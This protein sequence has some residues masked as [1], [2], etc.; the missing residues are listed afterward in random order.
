MKSIGEL[1]RSARIK[2]SLTLDQIE[3][4][5]KIHKRFIKAIEEEDWK[6]LPEFPVVV[7]FVKSIVSYLDI[8]QARALAFLRRDYPPVKLSLSPK[9]DI[10]K[11][12]VWGPRL[13]FA[14]GTLFILSLIIGYLAFQYI[15]F[16]RPPVLVITSPIENQEI[17]QKLLSVSGKTNATS[18]VKVNNQPATVNEDGTFQTEIE[19]T[20]QTTEIEVKS[21]SRSGKETVIKRKITVN[22]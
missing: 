20:P 9:P 6:H 18:S 21:V 7:G 22:F 17:T 1:I 16:K 3:E 14:L 4:K 5:T 8:D 15:R 13:I 10:S 11:S 19:L 2:H 12:F